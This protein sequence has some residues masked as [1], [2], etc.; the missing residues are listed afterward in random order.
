MLLL[1][2]IPWVIQLKLTVLS[3]IYVNLICV[4]GE[5]TDEDN[6]E[7]LARIANPEE[8][9]IDEDDEDEDA[10]IEGEFVIAHALLCY[11]DQI[12]ITESAEI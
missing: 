12:E 2:D 3:L 8:I 11:Y 5:A 6:L 1:I 4:K 10:K 9:P 7:A